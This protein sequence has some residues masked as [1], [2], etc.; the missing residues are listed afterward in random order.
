VWLRPLA[1]M[2]VGC[3]SV[4]DD[5]FHSGEEEE[6]PAKRALAAAEKLGIP[7]SPICIEKPF[8]EAA[9]GEDRKKGAAVIGGGAMFKGRA[10]EKLTAGLPRRPARELTECPHEDLQSPERVHIDSYG[11]VQICQGI[12]MGN[13]WQ[14]RLTEL[15]KEYDAGS[16]P[17]CGPLIRGGPALLAQRYGVEHEADYVDECHFCF[18]AR[19]ALVDGFP[20]YL[21]PRQVYGLDEGT[22]T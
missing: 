1:D 3:L 12:S 22:E 11:N 10:V 2:G 15:V 9:P 17:I 20:E 21:A 5:S 18:L 19:R 13:M 4:S 6:T 16:H 8:V 14:R 7:S